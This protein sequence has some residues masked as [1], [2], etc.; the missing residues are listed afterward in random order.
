MFPLHYP[1]SVEFFQCTNIVRKVMVY[2][3]LEPAAA[4]EAIALARRENCW[5]WV[6][7]DAF[8]PEE[9]QRLIAEGV[10]VTRF[11][12][13]LS[14]ASAEVVEG[15]AGIVKEHHQGEIVWV[16]HVGRF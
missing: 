10:K 3:A 9:F 1:H 14:R 5:V 8:A 6:G 4:R 11:A 12:Q 7:S 2:L 15:V 16:Q 13:P